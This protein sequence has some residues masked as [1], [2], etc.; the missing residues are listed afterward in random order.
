VEED[1]Q[2]I[3]VVEVMRQVTNAGVFGG[4]RLSIEVDA[5]VILA[6]SSIESQSP[7]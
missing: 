3:Q 4:G 6:Q 7:L 5:V 2:A 1:G